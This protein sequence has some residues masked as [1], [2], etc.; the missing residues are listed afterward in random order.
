MEKCLTFITSVIV[1]LMLLMTTRSNCRHSNV[2]LIQD[3]L[4][5]GLCGQ[6]LFC[7]PTHYLSTQQSPALHHLFQPDPTVVDSYKGPSHNSYPNL[8]KHGLRYLAMFGSTDV[9]ES[10]FNMMKYIKN[11]YRT[12]SL[13]ITCMVC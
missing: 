11:K 1:T 9:C 6:I 3:S 4:I 13:M 10:L 8:I 5:S 12:G 2:N 7:S